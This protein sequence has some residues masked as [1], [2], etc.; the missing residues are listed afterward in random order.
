[1]VNKNELLALDFH[2]ITQYWDYIIESYI[3]GQFGQAKELYSEMSVA[4]S[5]D[6]GD[7]ITLNEISFD[8]GLLPDEFIYFLES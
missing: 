1:M 2:D 6:F 8:I 3:N 7:Y 5:L 4:Q